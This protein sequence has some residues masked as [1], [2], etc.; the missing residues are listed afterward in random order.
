MAGRVRVSGRVVDKAGTPVGRDSAIAVSAG[1]RFVS[2]AGEKLAHALEVFSLNV[3]GVHALD[4]GASTGGFVDCLLQAGA[5]AVVALDVGY[6]QLDAGLRA[7]TRV[8]VLDRIN[9]RY[10]QPAQLPYVP[11]FLTT[12]VSFIS[13]EKVLP[14]VT[15]C[16]APAFRGVLLVKPQ[17]E[18]GPERVGKGGIVRDPGVRRDVLRRIARFVVD[19]L[20]LEIRGVA[21]SGLPGTGGNIEFVMMVERGGGTGLSLA[22]LEDVIDR[23]R[24]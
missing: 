5:A 6:G 8:H 2:R 4:V 12:D 20:G 10:L 23:F 21:P 24:A 17:F 13:L 14:A 15:A 9:A 16:M 22:T 7:D 19:G 18:A 1:P 3:V 11:D